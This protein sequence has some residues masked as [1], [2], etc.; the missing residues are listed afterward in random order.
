MKHFRPGQVLMNLLFSVF[1]SIFLLIPS[2]G[3]NP[4]FSIA[5]K[6]SDTLKKPIESGSPQKPSNTQPFNE[7]DP[8][9]NV[10]AFPEKTP[11]FIIDSLDSYISRGMI[12]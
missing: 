11:G 5:P 6:V 10:D 3:Q 1:F 7:P 2:L 8:A 4:A 9:G 12:Q